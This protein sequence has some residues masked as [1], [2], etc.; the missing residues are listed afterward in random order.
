MP[1]QHLLYDKTGPVVTLTLHRPEALNALNPALEAELHAA[2]DEADADREVRAI[3]LTGAGRAFSAGYDMAPSPEQ[4][5]SRLDPSGLSLGEYLKVWWDND[6]DN[7]RKLLHLWQ[8]GTP[9]IAAVNGWAMGG[10]FWYALACDIT[11]ASEEAVFG[12][13]EVRHISNTTFLFAALAGWKAAHRYA[14]TG[15]HLDAYE[16]LRLGL[17]NEVVPAAQLLPRARALAERIAKVPEPSVRLNKAI[18]CM[19]LQAAGL[20]GGLLLNGVLS[21]LAHASHLPL[22]DELFVAMR[23]GGMRAFLE[24]RDAPFRPEPFG[25]KAQG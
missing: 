13:P 14:L 2:L 5:R 20:Y 16:A 10:G 6:T 4:P 9:V 19:G 21:T 23:Q 7:V 18:T 22:R 17:V 24:K 1:Y 8:L 12:Q 15:D 11:L 3:I 25:P